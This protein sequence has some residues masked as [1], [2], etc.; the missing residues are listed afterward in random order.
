MHDRHPFIY[1]VAQPENARSAGQ[2]RIE[3]VRLPA[4]FLSSRWRRTSSSASDTT[5]CFS[6]TPTSWRSS[7]GK[8]AHYREA[9]WSIR[10]CGSWRFPPRRPAGRLQTTRSGVTSLYLM[11]AVGLCRVAQAGVAVGCAAA[12]FRKAST[13]RLCSRA[14]TLWK[15]L[16]PIFQLSGKA[17]DSWP[18]HCRIRVIGSFEYR[19]V[20]QSPL[21]PGC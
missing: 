7:R 17:T 19:Q 21:H 20:T 6:N 12:C 16:R 8:P 10:W 14:K 18:D 5:S 2:R 1:P 15:K 13:K 9:E 3:A 4:S 11:M